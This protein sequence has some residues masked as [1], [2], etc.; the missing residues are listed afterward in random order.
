MMTNREISKASLGTYYSYW[1]AQSSV[2]R[3]YVE[4][5]FSCK[6]CQSGETLH[7]WLYIDWLFCILLAKDPILALKETVSST[8]RTL[9]GITTQG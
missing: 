2:D 4:A 1:V 3:A 7:S 5:R 9:S 6:R 8:A